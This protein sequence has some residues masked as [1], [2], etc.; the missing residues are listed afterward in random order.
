MVAVNK[1]TDMGD[2]LEARTANYL[3]AKDAKAEK[4]FGDRKFLV[5]IAG[6]YDAL[7]L[8]GSEH[9]GIAVLDVDNE[10]VV[11]DRHMPI[12]SGATGPSLG[13]RREM[14]RIM[15][16]DWKTF[17]AF[18]RSHPRY[19]GSM[20][21]VAMPEP[22]GA[23][24]FDDRIIYPD[25]AR[26]EGNPYVE[27]LHTRK[28]IVDFLRGHAFHSVSGP[29]SG[30][31]LAW[32]IKVAPF[33]PSAHGVEG[34]EVDAKFDGRWNDHVQSNEYL[35]GEACEQGLSQYVDDLY[36][37]YEG[38]KQGLYG[39]GTAGRSGGWLVLN[40]FPGVREGRLEW[41]SLHEFTD[42]L[43]EL[44]DEDLV[45]LYRLVN[46]VD[47]DLTPAKVQEEM[48]Y[49]YASIRQGMEETW[50]QEM[51]QAPAP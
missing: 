1:E 15:D 8:I 7:G 36:T 50:A 49:Q 9:N 5:L 45:H 44:K 48:R 18:I 17:T 28:E 2:G 26:V 37:L 11:L 27:P 22:D 43:L 39:F 40:K 30:F 47:H 46:Q 10:N 41:K 20:P 38:D 23:L 3:H 13:Q 25:D 6:A 19:R 24:P 32:D 33:D 31:G 4:A 35:F 34:M 51:E 42:F 29:Y 14:A 21:D 16:M 12:G